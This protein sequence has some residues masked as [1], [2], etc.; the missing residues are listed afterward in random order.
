MNVSLKEIIKNLLNTPREIDAGTTTGGNGRI[1]WTKWSNGIL[2]I[3]G[4]LTG[5]SLTNYSTFSPFNGYYYDLNWVVSGNTPAFVDGRYSIVHSWY[6]GGG[7]AMAATQMNRNS[8]GIRLYALASASGT[9]SV[10][11]DFHI[12]GKWK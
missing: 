2:E 11:I 7:F 6:I 4:S 1:Y 12:I 8:N 5:L 9:Q 10:E 3:D